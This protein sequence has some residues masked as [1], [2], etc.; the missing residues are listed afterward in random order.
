[1][2]AESKEIYLGK[3]G[4]DAKEDGKRMRDMEF[5]EPQP[6]ERKTVPTAKSKRALGKSKKRVGGKPEKTQGGSM[7]QIVQPDKNVCHY[8][9]RLC[10]M[11][12]SSLFT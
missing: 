4:L 9:K 11:L 6:K 12:F 2:S 7:W 3:R 8:R 1:M 10:V 5:A